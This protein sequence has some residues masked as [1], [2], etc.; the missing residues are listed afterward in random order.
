MK[1]VLDTNVVVS[2]LITPGGHC[3]VVLD[4][5]LDGS[6]AWILTRSIVA[7]Y[8][9]V[10]LR[11]ELPLG[12]PE[13]QALISAVQA[14]DILPDPSSHSNEAKCVDGDDQPFL[15]AALCY[16]A[17]CLVTGNRKHFPAQTPRCLRIVTPREFLIAA[18]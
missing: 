5:V 14:M 6:D 3:G 12:S 17:A 18:I 11:P 2:A 1:I 15:D 4:R 9:A 7:E 16:G 10:L 8:V 13:R